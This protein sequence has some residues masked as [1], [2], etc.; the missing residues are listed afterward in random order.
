MMDNSFQGQSGIYWECV[1]NAEWISIESWTL[2]KCFEFNIL[3]S[4]LRGSKTQLAHSI[5][6]AGCIREIERS[7][8]NCGIHD[9]G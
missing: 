8:D 7:R 6:A 4:S 2:V 9:V 3:Y 5:V 1:C